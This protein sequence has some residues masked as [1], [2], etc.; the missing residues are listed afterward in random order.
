[1]RADVVVD[2]NVLFRLSSY[3][4]Y[5]RFSSTWTLNQIV[6]TS[7][8]VRLVGLQA[9]IG[10]IDVTLSV[11]NANLTLLGVEERLLRLQ[12]DA[13]SGVLSTTSVYCSLGDPQ[14]ILVDGERPTQITIEDAFNSYTDT[15]YYYD[16]PTNT[17][18]VKIKHESPATLEINYQ[19]QSTPSGDGGGTTPQPHVD[20]RAQRL[21]I[22]MQAGETKTAYLTV[23]FSKTTTIEIVDV[24]FQE[25]ESWF[26]I[27][28][29]QTLRYSE[30]KIPVKITIP[31]DTPAATYHIRYVVYAETKTEQL[32]QSASIITIHVQAPETY[33][34][35]TIPNIVTI[36]MLAAFASIIIYIVVS[37]P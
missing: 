10:P 26:N 7:T 12:V 36:L 24:D 17:L 11:Q 29:P 23:E 8:E 31:P 25:H 2:E 22:T 14:V 20:I 37:R 4:T 13:S 1:V 21:S 27:T 34:E 5:F 6:V 18:K 28:L 16:T 3:D 35:T 33:V 30:N 32:L 19:Q 15:C 9:A